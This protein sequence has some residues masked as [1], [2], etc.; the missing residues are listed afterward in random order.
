MPLRAVD[1]ASLRENQGRVSPLQLWWSRKPRAA[2]RAVL[3]AALLDDPGPAQRAD[4]LDLVARVAAGEDCAEAR[5]LL[6]RA[7]RPAVL[8]PFCGGGS[9]PAEARRLGLRSV[10]GDL[11]PVAVLATRALID[12]PARFPGRNLA[13]EVRRVGRILGE[14]ARRRIGHAYP[15][16]DGQRPVA[17]IWARTTRCP[18]CGAAVPLA[19]SFLLSTRPGREAR[20]EGYPAEGTVSRR[21]VRCLECGT[22]APLAALARQGLGPDRLLATVLPGRRYLAPG[23]EQEAAA[24]AARPPG[25]PETALPERA[26]GLTAH[27]YGLTRHRDLHTPRQLLALATFADL[28]REAATLVDRADLPAGGP[29][30]AAGGAGASAFAA[31]VQTYLALALGRAAA[32]W[33]SFARWQRSR[34]N[35]EHAF[36]RPGLAMAWDFAEA[37]PFADGAGSWR[38]TVDTVARALDAAPGDG[39]AGACLALDAAEPPGLGQGYLVCTDPPYLDTLP[40]ADMAD[41]FYVW[42]RPA[43]AAAHPDLFGSPLTPKAAEIVA[44]PRRHGGAAAARAASR[45]RLGMAFRRLGELADR[46]HPLVF[47]Y[48]MKRAEDWETVLEALHASDLRVTASWPVRT[49]HG[50]RLRRVNSNTMA[51][52]IVL[53]CRPRNADAPPA[54]WPAIEAASRAALGPAV[55]RLIAMGITPVDLP[56]AAIGPALAVVGRFRAVAGLPPMRAILATIRAA[57]E[58]EVAAAAA[59]VGAHPL[60]GAVDERTAAQA[61]ALYAAAIRGGRREEALR[62]NDMVSTWGARRARGS[63]GPR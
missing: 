26:L 19:H 36:G 32:R 27:R 22:T 8:D 28:V 21:G 3:L 54:D 50:E 38:H 34:E 14:E 60:D 9:I 49:E 12:Y 1:A 2:C 56:Q 37:N 43:L 15:E 53:C 18:A 41:I 62:Y 23:P 20:S 39:P 58:A 46:D 51:C 16:V 17:W 35:V 45:T 44:D 13:A 31:A 7:P 24:R 10:A 11:N 29:S 61:H 40:Y 4:L 55:R 33:C 25:A 52:T 47:F 6:A 48:G 63:L 59:E 5:A 42:L 30:L 57:V